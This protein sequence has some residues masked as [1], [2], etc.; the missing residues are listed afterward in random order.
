MYKIFPFLL[1]EL[2]AFQAQIGISSF[3]VGSQCFLTKS[4]L[5]QEMSVLLSTRAWVS[6]A[7]WNLDKWC[8]VV[9]PLIT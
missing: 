3:V 9:Q 6:T 4:Q 2:S 1:S 8:A 7:C 5:M